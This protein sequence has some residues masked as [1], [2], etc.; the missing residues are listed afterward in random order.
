[1]SRQHR[2]HRQSG[3]LKGNLK[4]KRLV[5]TVCV[6]VVTGSMA[7]AG[8]I[9]RACLKA[10]RPAANRNLCGCIQDVADATLTRRDQRLAAKFFKNPPMAQDIRQSDRPV[11]EAFWQKY[12]DFGQTAKTYCG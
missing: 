10:D 1:M 4:M 6:L 5:L 3:Q 11:H 7:Q 8:L 2:R 9:E 12:K